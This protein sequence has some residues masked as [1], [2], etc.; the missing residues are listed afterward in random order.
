M[1]SLRRHEALLQVAKERGATSFRPSGPMH[2][3]PPLAL[4]ALTLSDTGP[5]EVLTVALSVNH[6]TGVQS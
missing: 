2:M 5:N 4:N 6:K 1:G 3:L